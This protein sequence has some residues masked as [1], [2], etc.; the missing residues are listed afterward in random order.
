MRGYNGW[1][2]ISTGDYMLWSASTKYKL[3][4]W[5]TGRACVFGKPDNATNIVLLD[6]DGDYV[7]SKWSGYQIRGVCSKLPTDNTVLLDKQITM[8]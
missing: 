7:T 6:N 2:D 3:S 4:Q 8:I 1:E 5:S